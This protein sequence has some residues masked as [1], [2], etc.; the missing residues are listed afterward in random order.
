MVRPMVHSIKHYVQ[1]PINQLLTG[2]VENNILVSGVAVLNKDVPSE[3][4]EGSTV[5]A[6]FVEMWL[7]N[8]G[9]L[10]EF[11]VTVSKQTEF[12]LGPTFAEM[13]LLQNYTNK[14]N[15]LYT[16][17]GLASNDGVSGPINILR[18]WI[19]IPKSKQRFG[20][21]D[22]LSLSISNVSSNDLVRCGFATYKEYN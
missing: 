14:K 11:I 17:Q 20:L 7:Q 15:I 5:K 1:L 19:K 3:V 4:V 18:T 13:A 9:T 21:G 16:T 22:L 8:E 6:V 10:S 12:Q 2:A